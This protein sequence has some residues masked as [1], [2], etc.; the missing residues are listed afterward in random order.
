MQDRQN[1]NRFNQLLKWGEAHI[2][3]VVAHNIHKKIGRFHEGGT[4]FHAFRNV[5]EYLAHDLPEN[6]KRDWDDGL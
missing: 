3:S 6:D 5:T 2:Q 1:I 4:S